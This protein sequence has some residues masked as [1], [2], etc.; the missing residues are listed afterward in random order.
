MITIDTN[1][2]GP[3]IVLLCISACG[4][5]ADSR[6]YPKVELFGGYQY[7]RIGGVGGV[8]ANGWNSA[9][10]GNATSW[11]GV[12]ADFSGAYKGIGDVNAKV[13]TFTFGPTFSRRGGRVTMFAHFLLGGFHASAGFG[14]LSGSTNGFTTMAGGG[15]DAK[16]T[17]HVSLRVFQADWLL[18]RTM[19]LTEKKNAR[20]STGLVFQF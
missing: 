17:S 14:G 12:T 19:G 4:A 2:L 13:H 7:T 10:T 5:L 11:F 8:N 15:V 6:E 1:K 9:I 16:I 3:L 20:I 18:W